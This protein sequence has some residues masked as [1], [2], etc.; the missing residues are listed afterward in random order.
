MGKISLNRAA[1]LM[2]KL[3]QYNF[4]TIS[5]YLFVYQHIFHRRVETGLKDTFIM[6]YFPEGPRIAKIFNCA[7]NLSQVRTNYYL[8]TQT[9]VL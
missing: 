8:P 2:Y 4:R 7:I 1:A 9:T 6:Y 3:Y 5:K